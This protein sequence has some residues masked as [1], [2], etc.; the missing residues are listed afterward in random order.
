MKK[1]L[2]ISHMA[3]IPGCCQAEWIDDRIYELLSRNYHITVIS[4][5]HCFKYKQEIN[6]YRIPSILPY[7]AKA[8]LNEIESMHIDIDTRP[9]TIKYLRIMRRLSLF[10]DRLNLTMFKGEG[11]WFWMFTSLLVGLRIMLFKK[12]DFIYTTGGPASAH[13]TG[14]LLS[15][16]FSCKLMVEL[17]DPLT[18]ED[19]G[20]NRLTIKGLEQIEKFIVKNSNHIVFATRNA[21]L[22]AKD[23]YPRQSHKINHIYPGAKKNTAG[24]NEEIIQKDSRI[25]FSYIGSL[26]QTR[27][28]DNFFKALVN[29]SIPV[30]HEINLYGWI[31]EDILA[32]IKKINNKNIKIHG[33]IS[34]QHAIEKAQTADVLLLV[35]HT[36]LRSKK[37]IPFKIY[38]YLNSKNLIF[39]LTYQ[40]EEINQLLDDHGHL[41]SDA[42]DVKDI[43]KNLKSIF[44]SFQT[45]KS[46]IKISKLTPEVAVDKMERIILHV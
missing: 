19:I 44:K 8:E 23:R 37:T 29:L 33:M 12:F 5:S 45:L 9:Y 2:V 24:F 30:P 15:K 31:A 11:R 22:S 34:R 7:E 26:Y 27:N 43:E 41:T 16:L 35:Q 20:R 21:S 42:G 32:R 28:L 3:N 46:Q 1:I 40:N 6:H 38:D 13:L 18:G 36:D 4:G 14:I 25:N 17:Q 39:G 10:L